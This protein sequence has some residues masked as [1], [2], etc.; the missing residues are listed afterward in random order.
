MRDTALSAVTVTLQYFVT[1]DRY[2][3]AQPLADFPAVRQSVAADGGA[4][5]V[6]LHQPDEPWRI[7]RTRWRVGGVVKGIVEGSGRVSGYFTG[8]TG[9]T[10]YRGDAYG[11]TFLWATR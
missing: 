6:L 3:Q 4:A 7:V 1:D 2:L 5:G 11:P 10:V 9:T 8:A